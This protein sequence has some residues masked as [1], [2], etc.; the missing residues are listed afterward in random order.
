MDRLLRNSAI[1]DTETT[2]LHRGAGL[3]EATTYN[4]DTKVAQEYLLNPNRVSVTPHTPQDVAKFVASSQDIH[5]RMSVDAWEKVIVQEL[6]SELG[7]RTNEQAY[8]EQARTSSNFLYKAIVAGNFPQIHSIPGQ[9]QARLERLKTAGIDVR[10]KQTTVQQMLSEL[11]DHLKGKTVW[12]A[13]VNFESKQIGSQL[14]ADGTSADF[15]QRL[16][17]ETFST[18]SPDPF[19]V[20]GVEVNKARVLAQ[21][22]GD[23]RG[24][25]KAYDKYTPLP[26]ETAVRDIQDLIR[27]AMSYGREAKLLK[28]GSSYFGTGIDISHKLMALAE[29]DMGRAAW[30]EAHRSTE[31]AAIH[32][33]Y[34]L[35]KSV[36]YNR[37]LQA[38]TE[39]T[40]EGHKALA[41]KGQ[42]PLHE[43]T[44]YF[45]LLDQ[46]G[47][48]LERANLVKRLDRAYQDIS[49]TGVTHQVIG[50]AGF[51]NMSQQTPDGRP[52]TIAR[53]QHATQAFRSMD[54][55][56]E[57]LRARKEYSAF[58]T[59]IANEAKAFASAVRNRAQSTAYVE[60]EVSASL[61]RININ[62]LRPSV[63]G[64]RELS[65]GS[66]AMDAALDIAGKVKG[67]NVLI[68]AG[69]MT[70]MGAAWSLVQQKP[71]D[72]S[73]LIGYNY[74]DWLSA[75][76]GMS[77][78]GL[79]KEN[80]AKNTD[81]GSPYRGPVVSN[82]VFADQQML[83]E[84]ENWLRQKYGGQ[85]YDPMTG[86]FGIANVFRMNTGREYINSGTKVASGYQGMRG[87]NLVSLNLEDGWKLSVDDADTLTIKRGG[88]RG[89]ITDF[90]GLNRGYS[91]RLAGID[92]P[93][94]SHKGRDAQPYA[95]AAT[96]VLRNAL[97]TGKQREIIFDPTQLTYGRMMAGVVVDGRNLNYEMVRQGTV[98]HLPFGK[99]SNAIVDYAA[100]KKAEDRAGGAG[101]GMWAEPWWAG[102]RDMT[103]GGQR[104]TFNTLADMG[105]VVSNSGY[106]S[107]VAKANAAQAKGRWDP[108]TGA[109]LGRIGIG[110]DPV[111]AQN[112]QKDP[113]DSHQYMVELLTDTDQFMKTH[114]TNTMQNKFSHRSGFGK[115]NKEMALDTAGSTTSSWTKRRYDAF[116]TYNTTD[117]I[118]E[119]RKRYM[120]ERQRA[121][122]H[123]VFA[124]PI[125]HHRM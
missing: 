62:S 9:E 37:T 66:A 98:A 30:V 69:V 77:E 22:T 36:E 28:P 120:A 96:E 60:Q 1:L 82:E 16:G 81:F 73:S 102:I 49:Q 87:K 110:S 51:V 14:A 63:Q 33:A 58:G 74:Y 57:H 97:E 121:Q 45:S 76:E 85:H 18:T 84:R 27:S 48:H 99:H 93:E 25:F 41:K 34:V 17:L 75:Q 11:P 13:N 117:T 20:T 78:V 67:R 95:N 71:K 43:V 90:F 64:L 65:A 103:S 86:L 116:D 38:V 92:A 101:K 55:F 80:R 61:G 52:V 114:G 39:G 122:N 111:G 89:A 108:L 118:N 112:W 107:M 68:G 70:A 106:M 47:P 91:F 119:G 12:I 4:L 79:A 50:T 44:K 31:D 5:T 32:E 23:W 19:H 35:Q 56:T 72:Q 124:S 83:A 88:V 3:R 123:K 54:D 109:D 42:G 15:K 53:T 24:V 6:F 21:Y 100:M 26:G 7:I 8:L 113:T 94:T 59:D 115:L 125:G 40:A 10:T 46:V 2:A 29:G 104:P 105:K